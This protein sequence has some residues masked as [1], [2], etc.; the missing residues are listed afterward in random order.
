MDCRS[1]LSFPSPPS[2]P[3]RCMIYLPILPIP[4]STPQLKPNGIP[5]ETR[6]IIRGT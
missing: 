5:T 3:H 2:I 1:P 4:H 6:E